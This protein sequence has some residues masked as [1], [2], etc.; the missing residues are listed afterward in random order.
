MTDIFNIIKIASPYIGGVGAFIAGF[1][2]DKILQK[3]NI[4]KGNAEVKKISKETD[5]VYISNSEKLVEIYGKS[6]DDLLRRNKE[7][8]QSIESKHRQDIEEIKQHFAKERAID[9]AQDEK[10]EKRLQMAAKREKELAETLNDFSK[11]VEKLKRLVDK[12]QRQIKFY[13][14]HSDLELPQNLKD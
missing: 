2:K 7:A 11:E 6:M 14:K 12:L 5:T 9:K 3:L 1:Y 4:K 8:I 10:R 13:Q